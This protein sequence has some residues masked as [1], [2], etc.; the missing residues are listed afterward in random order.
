MAV[1]PWCIIWE[2]NLESNRTEV[3]LGEKW[4][5]SHERPAIVPF[6]HCLTIYNYSSTDEEIERIPPLAAALK[7]S[8]ECRRWNSSIKLKNMWKPKKGTTLNCRKNSIPSSGHFIWALSNG[9][10]MT[11]LPLDGKV[12]QI[13]F[14]M[15]T[16]R[17]IWK[18][19]PFKRNLERLRIR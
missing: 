11:H 15:V 18:N 10:W 4:T 12:K 17:P 1:A 5:S 2:G 3:P 7:Y 6:W 8:C 13:T 9:T 19:S 16:L 14:E